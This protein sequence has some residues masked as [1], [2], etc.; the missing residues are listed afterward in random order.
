MYICNRTFSYKG[1]FSSVPKPYCCIDDPRFIG[2]WF[3]NPPGFDCWMCPYKAR[4][5]PGQCQRVW[6]L[7]WL[8]FLSPVQLHCFNFINKKRGQYWIKHVA[9]TTARE[10]GVVVG[11]EDSGRQI[12]GCES[13]NLLW[14]IWNKKNTRWVQDFLASF[15]FVQQHTLRDQKEHWVYVRY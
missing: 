15:Q 12:R 1:H 13:V 8:N 6:L 14:R 11:L 3:S 2:Q 10:T 4:T 5:S 9:R 7:Q